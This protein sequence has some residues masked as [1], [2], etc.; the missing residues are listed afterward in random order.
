M[1]RN[2]FK[3]TRCIFREQ[4][5]SSAVIHYSDLIKLFSFSG[6]VRATEHQMNQPMHNRESRASQG[7][8]IRHLP[9]N[10]LCTKPV[11]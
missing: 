4:E 6:S 2:A 8:S 5:D 9:G 3:R 1:N 7:N 10:L 11:Y